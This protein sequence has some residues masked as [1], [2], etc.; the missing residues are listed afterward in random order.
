MALYVTGIAKNGKMATGI[1]YGVGTTSGRRTIN[2]STD[3]E[4][5]DGF[6]MQK[7]INLNTFYLKSDRIRTRTY[8]AFTGA[9]YKTWIKNETWMT[10]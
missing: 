9:Q 1:L 5:L 7:Y 6:T 8:W 3:A 10:L 2:E 4:S